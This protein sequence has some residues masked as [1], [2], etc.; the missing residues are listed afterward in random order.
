MIGG[1]ISGYWAIGR[2]A[3][4]TAPRITNTVETTAAKIGRSMKKCD[5]RILLSCARLVAFGLRRAGRR[6][7]L[8][9]WRDLTAGPRP[10]QAV[11]DDAVVGG[12]PGLDHPQVVDDVAQGHVFLPRDVVGADDKDVFTRLL[13]AD[14]DIRQQQRLVRRRT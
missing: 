5:M 12:E 9:L 8:L 4:A 14:R 6:R 3:K 2:R 10:H 11:D 1:A 7:A 13:G